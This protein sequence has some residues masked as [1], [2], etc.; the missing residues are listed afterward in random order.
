[1]WLVVSNWHWQ[2]SNTKLHHLTRLVFV[3]S[4]L[5]CKQQFRETSQRL[6]KIK[7]TARGQHYVRAST[8]CRGWRHSAPPATSCTRTPKSKVLLAFDNARKGDIFVKGYRPPVLTVTQNQ[9]AQTHTSDCEA[10]SVHQVI[11]AKRHSTRSQMLW[12]DF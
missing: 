3:S 8:P 6:H 10:L 1:M 12:H 11:E 2:Q 4:W 7:Q 5:K 9:T